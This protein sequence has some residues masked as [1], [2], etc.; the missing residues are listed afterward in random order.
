MFKFAR[1]FGEVPVGAF[2]LLPAVKG[3]ANPFDRVDEVDVVV[4]TNLPFNEEGYLTLINP[5]TGECVYLKDG[6]LDYRCGVIY[7]D[8][9]PVRPE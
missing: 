2:V 6:E 7:T 8:C 3:R 9:I 1:T 5:K 4:K